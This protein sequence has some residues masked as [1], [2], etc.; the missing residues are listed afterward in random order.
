MC[1]GAPG[2]LVYPPPCWL[3]LSPAQSIH[4]C[5]FR[6]WLPE[7][8][9]L[10]ATRLLGQWACG[11]C[12]RVPLCPLLGVGLER[13]AVTLHPAKWSVVCAACLGR[14]GVMSCVSTRPRPRLWCLW[15]KSI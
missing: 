5:W 10:R 4:S 15:V 2:L 9:V 6:V 12:C 14:A 1:F 3:L 13:Q 8:T 7:L 11:Q